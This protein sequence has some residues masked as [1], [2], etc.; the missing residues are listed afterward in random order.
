[1]VLK[2][3]RCL[4]P[5]EWRLLTLQERSLIGDAPKN[6]LAFGDPEDPRTVGY[7]AKSPKNAGAR[8]CMTEE[9]I[10]KIGDGLP[11]RVAHSKLVRLPGPHGRY[12]DVRFM[13]EDFIRRGEA[14][15]GVLNY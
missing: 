3:I 4:R 2:R 9:I 15:G 6:Y 8:E 13:S 7:I 14:L 5:G 11:L 12:D 10:S 1:M